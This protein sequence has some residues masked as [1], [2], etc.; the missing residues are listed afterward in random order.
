MKS[1]RQLCAALVLTFTLSAG[2]FAG[3]VDC[4]G[5]TD[6]PPPE[7]VTAAGYIPNGITDTLILL[8][9]GLV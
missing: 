6:E 1:L 9:L 3:K 2:A 7:D 4:P 5:L 8:V